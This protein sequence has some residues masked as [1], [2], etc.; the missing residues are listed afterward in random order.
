MKKP[1]KTKLTEAQ[2]NEAVQSNTSLVRKITEST[3]QGIKMTL[4]E[5]KQWIDS[6]SSKS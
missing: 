4:K 5:A 3:G 1:N 6:L 2:I